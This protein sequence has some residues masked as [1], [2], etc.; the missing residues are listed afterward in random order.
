MD[1]SLIEPILRQNPQTR[2]MFK[3]CFPA[4]KLPSPHQL[5]FPASLV[6]NLDPE[7]MAGSHWVAMFAPGIGREIYY[8]DS[9]ALPISPFI[10]DGFLSHF[11]CIVRNSHAYQSAKAQTCPHF[12]IFFIYSLSIGQDFSAFLNVLHSQIDRDL[13]IKE[14]VNKL[15]E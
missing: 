1:A 2:K 4:D 13:F 6:A 9:L 8:F 7:G 10:M 11:P 12:C 3:G 14:I 5:L 15:I